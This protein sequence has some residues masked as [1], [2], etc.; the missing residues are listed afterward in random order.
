[1]PTRIRTRIERLESL[2]SPAPQ[3]LRFRHQRLAGRVVPRLTD[4]SR[5]AQSY[6]SRLVGC[7]REGRTS[8]QEISFLIRSWK[9][10]R[11][12]VDHHPTTVLLLE[13][14]S[15]GTHELKGLA[16]V[17]RGHSLIP[18]RTNSRRNHTEGT[19]PGN[20]QAKGFEVFVDSVAALRKRGNESA[21]VCPALRCGRGTN[22]LEARKGTGPTGE[23]VPT[24]RRR[25]SLRKHYWIQT[26]LN[27]AER[28]QPLLALS[29]R[30]G[31]DLLPNA[32][33]SK[34]RLRDAGPGSD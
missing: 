1:M 14:R 24:R 23:V 2:V 8:R 15:P 3:H 10:I 31:C 18:R 6:L 11:G 27:G 17:S 26:A 33:H 20:Q 16:E 4:R 19:I 21:N 34:D 5:Q 28:S 22:S 32:V 29:P 25:T 7:K 13:N 9:R 30:S 12:I